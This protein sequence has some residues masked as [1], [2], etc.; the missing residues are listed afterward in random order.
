MTRRTLKIVTLMSTV[1]LAISVLLFLLG[2]VISPWDHFLSFGD[3]CHVGVWGRGLDS[4]IVFFNDAEE[5]PYCGSIIGLVDADGNVQPPLER[6][7]AFGDAW[8]IYYR[9]FQWS[10]STLWT[11]TVTLWYPI[12][13]FTIILVVSL[14]WWTRR[15]RSA[16]AA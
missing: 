5:G 6:E 12:A 2:Y 9:Y 11:L 1:M 10:D 16:S 4:R 3:D 7:A 15:H 8:G 13:V 14:L